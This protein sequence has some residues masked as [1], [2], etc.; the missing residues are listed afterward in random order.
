MTAPDER[1]ARMTLAT[2]SEPADIITGTL[3]ARVGPI[4]TLALLESRAG[5]PS[6]IDPAEGELWR[7]RL[8]ARLSPDEPGRIAADMD[9]HQ[10]RMIT[11]DD[12]VWPT[13]LRHLGATTPLVLWLRG[14]PARLTG[15]LEDRYW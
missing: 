8:A 9:R 3:V 13:E 4:E 12:A 6:D 1:T 5:L 10:L 2:V 7:R 14:D 15:P 11:P